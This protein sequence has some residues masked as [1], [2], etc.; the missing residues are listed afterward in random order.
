MSRHLSLE[1][2]Y[3]VNEPPSA[4]VQFHGYGNGR[5]AFY[6][7]SL[8]SVSYWLSWIGRPVLPLPFCF[9]ILKKDSLQKASVDLK[10]LAGSKRRAISD[11]ICTGL[12][13]LEAG[14]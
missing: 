1:L 5:F 10:E 8:S 9:S 3:E 7:C 6:L 4:D 11:L 14:V 2:K 13:S 12:G